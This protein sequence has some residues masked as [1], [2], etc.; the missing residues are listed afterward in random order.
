MISKKL[1]FFILLFFVSVQAFALPKVITT[2]SDLGAIV[3]EI[4]GNNFSVTSICDGTRDPHFLEAKPSYILAVSKADLVIAN[5]LGLEV[6]W[7]PKLLTAAR[8]P[9]VTENSSGYL[10]VGSAVKVLEI[11]EGP[12]NRSQ[13]DVHPEGNPHV[14]LD[15]IRLG[16][17]AL[18]I[19]EKL[20]KIVPKS[21]ESFKKNALAFQLKLQE[22]TK[23]WQKR[24]AASGVKS[25]ITHHKTLTYFFDRFGITNAGMLE[26]FPGVPPTAKHILSVIQNASKNN[27]KMILIENYFDSKIAEK[28]ASQI[29]NILVA[30]VP[31]AVS[32]K[33]KTSFDLFEELVATIESYKKEE[34]KLKEE[35][36]AKD[37]V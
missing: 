7:L 1:I 2:T 24:I 12:I 15:P 17:I 26:P 11:P 27:V 37:Q 28:A 31:V 32:S 23:D 34:K 30:S 4:G 19:A 10:E 25:V 18:V 33:N 8:N 13:G 22:K 36:K 9:K 20:G 5:G 16:E 3:G 29:P 35:K 21:A 14:T 6:G